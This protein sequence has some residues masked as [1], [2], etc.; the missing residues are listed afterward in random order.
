MEAQYQAGQLVEATITKIT[1]YGAFARIN[2]EY[3]L[4]GL[5]HIS[6]LSAE[7]VKH[8]RDMVQKGDVVTARIIR[9]DPEQ[10]QLGLSI[11]RASSED[12]MAEDLALAE[13]YEDEEVSSREL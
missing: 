12:F 9:I 7:H 5:I 10:R 11:K 13:N 3:E 2:D 4:E 6:E 1:K 8:P